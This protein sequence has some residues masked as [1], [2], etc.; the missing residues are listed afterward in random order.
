MTPLPRWSPQAVTAEVERGVPVLVDLQAEWCA[1]CGPQER[2]LERVAPD[3]PD[4]VFVALDLAEHPA[5]ADDHGV[6]SLP[7]MLLFSSG[8][9]QDTLVGFKR[10][11]LVRLALDRL[12][13][14]A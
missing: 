5:A 12:V 14:S 6:R 1:Q 8:E 2:I 11:P 9:L 13:A 3:Y 10:A 7:A 4:V